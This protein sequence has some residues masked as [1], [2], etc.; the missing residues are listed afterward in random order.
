MNLSSEGYH[1]SSIFDN[2]DRTFSKKINHTEIFSRKPSKK[3]QK[4]A[5]SAANLIALLG[6]FMILYILFVPPAERDALLD[7]TR[8]DTDSSSSDNGVAYIRTLLSEQ[9]GDLVRLPQQDFEYAIPSFTLR[10]STYSKVLV[11]ENPF[12]VRR[13]WF[14]DD[15]KQ[16]EFSVPSV[17]D[18]IRLL[19][20]FS[21]DSNP[22]GDL[23]IILNGNRIYHASPGEGP[24]VPLEIPVEHLRDRNVL[25]LSSSLPGM[26]FWDSTNFRIRG[27]SIAG[28]FYEPEDLEN[29]NNFFMT[30]N[31]V[32]N[33][34][35]SRLTFSPSCTRETVGRLSININGQSIFSAI[36]DCNTLNRI[37]FDSKILQEDNI[38][39]FVSSGGDYTISLARITAR[40]DE[41]EFPR[42][43]FELSEREY[44]EINSNRNYIRV[45][46][47]LQDDER[48]KEAY[49]L[50]NSVKYF[51]NTRSNSFET[52]VEP[53]VLRQGRN[54]IELQPLNTF[55]ALNLKVDLL[56]N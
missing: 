2:Q 20:T 6:L 50:V 19:L 28:D 12:I 42:Y 44:N 9:P 14:S 10:E 21:V 39:S 16:I 46:I 26:R 52:K 17:R 47:D 7:G 38:I 36:P 3:G 40:L 32:N 35:S 48:F 5:A 22:K 11:E 41:V 8:T 18:T 30:E 1:A 25:T 33:L 29:Y 51:L 13:S 56:E 49:V 27:L 34:E 37:N 15:S 45:K 4:D 55:T 23:E 31:E 53:S 43:N 24:I 54:V